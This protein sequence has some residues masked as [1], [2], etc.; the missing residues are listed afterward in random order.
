[1]N[2][3]SIETLAEKLNGNLWI[4]GDLK[5]IYLDRGNNTKKMSTKTFVFQNEEGEFKV[6]CHVDCP[7]QPWQ[8]CQSQEDEVKEG[9]YRNIENALSDTVYILTDSEGKIIDWREKLVALNN[10]SYELTEDAAKKEIDN[11][12]YF[13]KFIT[14]PRDEF[15]KEVERLDKIEDDSKIINDIE[16]PQPL[17]KIIFRDIPD[18]TINTKSPEYGVGTKVN[19]SKFGAG[20]IEAESDKIVD[21]NFET[22]GHKQLVK[23]FAKLKKVEA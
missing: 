12:I 21:I 14:M 7:S 11:C 2:T 17:P 4:K 20:I 19:H 8:W 15:E 1:M 23:A 9:V 13:S 16:N 18:K 3:I 5:R 10:C 22:A 6:S